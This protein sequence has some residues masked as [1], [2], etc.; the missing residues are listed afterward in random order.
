[1]IKKITLFIFALG[2]FSSC[3][4]DDKET[5]SNWESDYMAAEFEKGGIMF[6]RF[7]SSEAGIALGS[8]KVE[9]LQENADFFRCKQCHAWDGLGSEGSYI[10]RSPRAYS[11][12]KGRPNVHSADLYSMVSNKDPK[13]LFDKLKTSEGRRSY[14]TD[15]TNYDP[16][17]DSNKV[18]GDKM[19]DLSELLTDKEIWNLVKF[20]RDEMYD[21]AD[22]FDA[23]YTGTYPSGSFSYS[24]H[25]LDGNY[26]VGK[27]FYEAN[28]AMCHGEDGLNMIGDDS[29]GRITRE[30]AYEV[31]HKVKYGVL[32]TPMKGEFDISIDQMKGLYKYMSDRTVFP[33][34][35]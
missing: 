29:I 1:M 6:D 18:D 2:L 16:S 26:E 22:I 27:S 8:D 32:G 4:K 24:N 21:V 30:K 11:T 17:D 28:C 3:A 12:G 19:P 20:L 14:D 15:L 33:D 31:Q 13:D 35:E 10:S 5:G 25:G 7:W 9:H 34:R 23:E